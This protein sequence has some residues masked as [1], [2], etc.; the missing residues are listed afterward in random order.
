MECKRCSA[1][2]EPIRKAQ[3][4]CS[5]KCRV[6]DAVSRHRSDYT[7]QNPTALPEKRL[8]APQPQSEGLGEGPTMVWPETPSM[9]GLN[10]EGST[11]GALQGDAIEL[12]YYEDGYPKL[13]ACL[14][15]GGSQS[16]LQRQHDGMGELITDRSRLR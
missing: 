3:L 8:Q 12:A 14:I 10:P 15:E 9:E 4:Y 2:F 13:P 16:R 5:R 6:A 1:A 11:A 7:E